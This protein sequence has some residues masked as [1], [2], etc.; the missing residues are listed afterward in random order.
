MYALLGISLTFAL[1]FSLTEF[2]VN[3]CLLFMFVCFLCFVENF[4]YF[5]FDFF[6]YGVFGKCLFVVYVCFLFM[7]VSMCFCLFVLSWCKS[8]D[9]CLVRNFSYFRFDFFTYGVLVNVCLV[10]FVCFLFCLFVYVC[11]CI[12]LYMFVYLVYVVCLLV[13]LIL[14]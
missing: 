10:V 7:F 11:V 5:R 8:T 14:C 1:T 13:S 4:T 3:V 12:C 2:L 6:T 9:V